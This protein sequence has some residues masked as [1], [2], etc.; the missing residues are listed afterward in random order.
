MEKRV[1]GTKIR[2]VT[3]AF[4]IIGVALL[5]G[6][7]KGFMSSSFGLNK[8]FC[9]YVEKDRSKNIIDPFYDES[10]NSWYVFLPGSEVDY[11]LKLRLQGYESIKIGEQNYQNNDVVVPEYMK[12]YTLKFGDQN[13]SISFIL[14]DNVASMFIDVKH[15]DYEGVCNDENHRTKANAIYTLWSPNK[16][17]ESGFL[18][19]KGHGNST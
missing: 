17:V 16:K 7:I 5:A 9:F 19:M 2:R 3:L 6:K 11:N 15:D 1:R 10:I 12:E 8:G 13:S 14:G 18:S 4:F